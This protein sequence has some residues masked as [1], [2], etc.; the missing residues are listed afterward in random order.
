[1]DRRQAVLATLAAPLAVPLIAAQKEGS[2]N[3]P[4]TIEVFSDFQCPSCK[5]LHESTLTSVKTDYVSKGKVR[6]LHREFPL[7]GH[8]YALEAACL[9]CASSRI[10]K[11]AQVSDALFRAQQTWSATGNLEAEL[12]K[13]LTP[14]EVAQVKALAKDPGVVAEVERDR[15]LGETTRVSQTP[16]MVIHYK[17]TSTPVAGAISYPILKRY[18]DDLLAR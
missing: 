9:A 18:L 13:A 8:K 16:T 15:K 5:Q 6:L 3:A 2:D 1:M 12:A 11:Y 10:G 14:A 7:P 4:V 17:S